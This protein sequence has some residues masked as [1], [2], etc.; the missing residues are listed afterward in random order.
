MRAVLAVSLVL[1]VIA[2]CTSPNE[3]ACSPDD[4]AYCACGAGAREARGYSTCAADGSGYGPCDC[5]GALPPGTF[6]PDDDASVDADGGPPLHLAD[7]PVVGGFGAPCSDDASCEPGLECYPFNAKGNRCS[8]PCKNDSDCPV[9]P[10][11]GCSN[12]GECKT[13]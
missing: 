10:G 6:P 11:L 7:A 8:R 4:V 13:P 2:A 1:L 9:P 3:T 12:K 5:S